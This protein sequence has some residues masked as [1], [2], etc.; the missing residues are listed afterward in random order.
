MDPDQLRD[1]F[2]RHH[3]GRREVLATAGAAGAA[4]KN[5]FDPVFR[6]GRSAA[7]PPWSAR[8][9]RA[10]PRPTTRWSTAPTRP[11]PPGRYGPGYQRGALN[12]VTPA[13]TASALALLRRHHDVQTYDLGEL[14]WNGFPAMRMQRP[15]TYQQRLTVS[16][17]RPPPGSRDAGGIVIGTEPLGVNRAGAHE[18]RFEAETSPAHP[19][20]PATTYRPRPR[21][22]EAG[23][24]ARG[25]DRHA[26]R[27]AGRPG[28]EAGPRPRAGP[29]GAGEQRPTAAARGPPHHR[30]GRHG[31]R[32]DPRR[33][34]G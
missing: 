25:A 24:R 34:T 3:V 26:W 22:R 8:R 5:H 30:R 29:G 18:E 15:G 21:H 17:H 13:K 7:G 28:R 14:R 20:P 19:G 11:P 23:R 27:A 10:P 12:E 32:R 33:R 9:P 2:T 16:G 31:V 4:W 1:C 6:A